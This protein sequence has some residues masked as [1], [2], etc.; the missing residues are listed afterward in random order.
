LIAGISQSIAKIN[1][2]FASYPYKRGDRNIGEE[3]SACTLSFR[4]E[5]DIFK[6]KANIL[7][8]CNVTKISQ[9]GRNDVCTVCNSDVSKGAM[10]P[11]LSVL[12]ILSL[13]KERMCPAA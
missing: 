10:P 9:F 13:A 2:Q 6:K 7:F 1:G 5:N 3:L 4:I 11:P 8:I 12:C